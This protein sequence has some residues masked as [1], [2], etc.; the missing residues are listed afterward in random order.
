MFRSNF[1]KPAR[2]KQTIRGL[3]SE[4]TKSV[5]VLYLVK[6]GMLEYKL[7]CIIKDKREPVSILRLFKLSGSHLYIFSRALRNI[8]SRGWVRVIYH[9]DGLKYFVPYNWKGLTHE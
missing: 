5:G 1:N 4:A 8:E 7:C 2:Q 6:L 9:K 3:F